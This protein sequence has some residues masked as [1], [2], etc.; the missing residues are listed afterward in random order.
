M[1]STS[2]EPGEIQ[3]RVVDSTGAPVKDATIF[4][5]DEGGHL[6]ERLSMIQSAADGTFKYNGVS[7]GEYL[8]SARG[9]NLAS[10]ESAP[11]RVPKAGSASV[12]PPGSPPAR[13]LSSRWIDDDA[14]PSIRRHRHRRPRPR[15]AG[16]ARMTEMA[17]RLR[18]RRLR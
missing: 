6:L 7:A 10:A 8:V 14:S 13:S 9:K 17:R 11:V 3:G 1:T 4:V 18:R 2:E 5:R 16:H 12:E 15:D